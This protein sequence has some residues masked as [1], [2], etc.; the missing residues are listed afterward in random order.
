MP[1]VDRLSIATQLLAIRAIVD[2]ILAQLADDMAPAAACEHPRAQRVNLATFGQ[3]GD[4]WR[5]G[6]CGYE[7]HDDGGEAA[8]DG[9]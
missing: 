8:L 3:A 4:H 6:A 2:G 9:R 5:C 1:D 7:H